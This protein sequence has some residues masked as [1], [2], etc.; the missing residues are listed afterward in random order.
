MASEDDVEGGESEDGAEFGLS[1]DLDECLDEFCEP[2]KV[3]PF[4]RPKAKAA[5][6]SSSSKPE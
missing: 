3:L 5:P 4:V 1:L 6:P 2:A